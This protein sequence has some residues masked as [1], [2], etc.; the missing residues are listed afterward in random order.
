MSSLMRPP[1]GGTGSPAG[2]SGEEPPAF[3]RAVAS[4]RGASVRADAVVREAPAPARL[5]PFTYACTVDLSEHATGR[6]VYL[7]DPD[8]QPAWSGC[9]RL[10]AFARVEVEPAMAADPMLSD[11]VWTW[12]VESLDDRVAAHA[13]LGGTVTTTASYRYGTLAHVAPQHEVELRCSWTPVGRD[14]SVRTIGSRADTAELD[15][16]LEPHLVALVT[17]LA[18]MCGLP[19]DVPGVVGLPTP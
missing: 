11:V 4:L 16:D 12:L 8:G 18:D 1:G 2:V 6:L 17:T 9:D 3:T 13:A 10:V 19:P 5:A 15:L 14:R 7:H